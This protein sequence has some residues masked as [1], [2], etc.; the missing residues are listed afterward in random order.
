MPVL[1]NIEFIELPAV[2]MIGIHVL[3]GGGDNPVHALW[4]RCFSEGVFNVLERL[5]PVI[6]YWV[7]WMGDYNPETGRFS[8]I[9][10]LLM[11]AGTAV[12]DGFDYR[13][14]APCI[15]GNG[16]ING[17]FSAPD[18]FSHSHDLTVSGIVKNGYEP[19]YSYGWS[20]EAYA[21]DL[22]FDAEAGTINYFCPCRKANK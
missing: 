7:G 12:P 11:P 18:A 2:R 3:H 17:D 6:A 13:D 22:A 19:D 4:D 20:A 14:L 15:V 5:S 16:F 10:G 1:G 9:A 8:Y 21:R